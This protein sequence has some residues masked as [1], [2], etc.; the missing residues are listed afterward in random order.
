WLQAHVSQ[1]CRRMEQ[2]QI[3][4]VIGTLW[5]P[6]YLGNLAL[7][8]EQTHAVAPQRHDYLRVNQF[9]LLEQIVRGTDIHLVRMWITV[10]RWPAF[11]YVRNENIVT[12]Q[13]DHRQ[14]FFEQVPRLPDER[15]P[16]LIFVEARPLANKHDFGV[17][18]PCAGHRMCPPLGQR[19]L[20]TRLYL[21]GN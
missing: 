1:D 16:L 10:A 9:D 20:A 14:E 18:R 6:M 13:F 21:G 15:Q 7:R 17:I 19:A 12:G 4:A 8:P 2:R 3:D 5:L 11:H